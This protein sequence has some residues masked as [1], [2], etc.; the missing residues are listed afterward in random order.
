MGAPEW[1][2][3]CWPKVRVVGSCLCPGSGV[4]SARPSAP[5]VKPS[6]TCGPFRTLDTMYAKR[7][8]RAPTWRAGRVSLA[9]LGPPLPGGRHLPHLP[10]VSLL[11]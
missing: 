3:E 8:R 11:L 7:G 4:I 10:G 2:S 1:G 9:A 6:G 5:R